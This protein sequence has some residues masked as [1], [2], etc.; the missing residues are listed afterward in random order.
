MNEEEGEE[1]EI[2][3]EGKGRKIRREEEGSK[4][5]RNGI[6]EEE[7]KRTEDKI[8]RGEEYSIRYNSIIREVE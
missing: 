7:G 5:K 1:E 2:D 4:M 6:E 3:E 8:R